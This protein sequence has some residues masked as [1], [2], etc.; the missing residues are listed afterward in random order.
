M[1]AGIDGRMA[2]L[3][4]E[5]FAR[6]GFGAAAVDDLRHRAPKAPQPFGRHI[7]LKDEVAIAEIRSALVLGKDQGFVL[8]DVLGFHRTFPSPGVFLRHM[9][10]TLPGADGRRQGKP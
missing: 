9:S 5:H 7:I 6:P 2:P 3:Q 10:E 4:H 1:Q 8:Q